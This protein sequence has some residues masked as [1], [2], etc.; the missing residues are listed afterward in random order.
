[1]RGLNEDLYDRTHCKRRI[2]VED[3]I[4]QLAARVIAQLDKLEEESDLDCW[5]K[6][7]DPDLQNEALEISE[8]IS[9]LRNKL[10]ELN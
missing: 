1:M 3:L 4:R 7:S 9:K 2:A 10:R 5:L 8:G 6:V